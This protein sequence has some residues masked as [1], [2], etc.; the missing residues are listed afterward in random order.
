MIAPSRAPDKSVKA[1]KARLRRSIALALG[2]AVM[3]WVICSNVAN[4]L[5][6]VDRAAV[7]SLFGKRNAFMT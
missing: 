6:L 1:I 7:L 3:V 5:R 4:S 2:M